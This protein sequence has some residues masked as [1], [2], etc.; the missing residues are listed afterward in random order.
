MNE[1]LQ[2]SKSELA[3]LDLL[4]D[5]MG[6]EKAAAAMADPAAWIKA[7]AQGAWKVAKKVTPVAVR[8]TPQM[9]GAQVA[10]DPQA[11]QLAKELAG[12]PEPTLEQL[13]ALRSLQRE[14]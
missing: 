12:M 4:I 3:A 11:Q 8:V 10:Q 9:V 14:Q 13:I 7:I 5:A 1:E 6:A 2:L